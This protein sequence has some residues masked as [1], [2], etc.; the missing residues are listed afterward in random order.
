MKLGSE[1]VGQTCREQS[2]LAAR[3]LSRDAEW[4]RR[5]LQREQRSP[6]SSILLYIYIY[7]KRK[8]LEMGSKNA[9]HLRER[10]RERVRERERG[11]I[12]RE[13]NGAFFCQDDSIRR[14]NI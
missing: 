11:R 2:K 7:R 6:F 13:T 10:E 1:Q 5:D 14:E 9:D 12:C 3:Y 4:N 8:R